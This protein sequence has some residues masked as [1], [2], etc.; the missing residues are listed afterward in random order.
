MNYSVFRDRLT[1]FLEKESKN[2]SYS[3]VNRLTIVQL[4]QSLKRYLKSVDSVIAIGVDPTFHVE[5]RIQLNPLTKNVKAM[6]IPLTNVG[7]DC[8][9]ALG[10]PVDDKLQS[11]I[12]K[13]Y[14]DTV[15]E[16]LASQPVESVY[17][18]QRETDQPEQRVRDVSR[19]EQGSEVQAAMEEQDLEKEGLGVRAVSA[20]DQGGTRVPGS[21]PVQVEDHPTGSD[22]RSG[23]RDD[24]GVLRTSK[25]PSSSGPE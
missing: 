5:V 8:I 4:E 20:P 6:L 18:R 11:R 25:E 14:N 19:Q 22:Q 1:S 21:L 17:N 16:Q 9:L 3:T 23:S 13:L 15:R 12:R 7:L 2:I 10:I 24:D